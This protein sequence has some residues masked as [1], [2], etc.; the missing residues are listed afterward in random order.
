L[1]KDINDNYHEEMKP[2]EESFNE[3]QIV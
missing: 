3:N 1:E 2:N